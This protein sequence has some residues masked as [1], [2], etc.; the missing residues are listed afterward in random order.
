M[1]VEQEVYEVV[2]GTRAEGADTAAYDSSK[3]VARDM[4]AG[5]VVQV[6]RALINI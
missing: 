1:S 3:M 5:S 4:Y 6:C 2:A